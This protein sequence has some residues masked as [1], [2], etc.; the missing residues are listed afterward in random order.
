[1]PARDRSKLVAT[2]NSGF[3]I[4]DSHGGWWTT[5]AAAVPLVDGRASVVIN[6][7]GSARV[8]AW[9][10][11]VRMTPDV[12]AVRQNLNMVISGGRIAGGL[13]TNVDGSWGSGRSQLQYTWRSGIGTNANGDLVYVAGRKLTLATLATAMHEAGITQG[14]ELDIHPSMVSFNIEQP[15]SNG[16]VTSKRLL[17]SMGSQADRYLADDQR[18]FFYVVAP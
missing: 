18:D 10:S 8:G 1:V 5:Q 14:M 11:D 13:A 7:D 12:V 16:A 4:K 2:F 6:R 15:G 9:N 17:E 3:K